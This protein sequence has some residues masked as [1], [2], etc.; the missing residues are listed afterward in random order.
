MENKFVP[1]FVKRCASPFYL[2]MDHIPPD[3]G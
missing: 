3:D 1:T 2:S